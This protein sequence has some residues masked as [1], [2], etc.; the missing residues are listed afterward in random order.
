LAV[1]FLGGGVLFDAR[2]GDYLRSL[3]GPSRQGFRVA[4]SGDSQLLAA[5]A[6][7][8]NSGAAGRGWDLSTGRVVYT[9][10]HP[11]ARGPRGVAFSPDGKRLFSGSTDRLYV[12]DARSGQ[13]IQSVALPIAGNQ[14]ISLSPNGR[15]LAVA[16]GS[17][18]GVT[19]LDWAGDRLTEVRTLDSHRFL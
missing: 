18:N 3:N 15:R 7:Q 13:E 10:E 14:S 12:W 2:T 1:A 5:T 4:F 16:H 6:W 17:G 11:M 9:H 8:A 19:V